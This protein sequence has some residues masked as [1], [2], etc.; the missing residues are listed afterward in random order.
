MDKSL[1]SRQLY[2]IGKDAMNALQTS[3]ILISGMTGLGVEVAKCVILSG[4][5]SV[6]L[7]DVGKLKQKELSSNYYAQESDIGRNRV[8][9]VKNMLAK[10]NPYVTV[11]TNTDILNEEHFKTNNIVVICDQLMLNQ[12][13]NN[14]IARK[15]GTKY[16]LANTMGLMGS[17][18]C[19]FGDIFNINDIDGETPKSGIIIELKDGNFCTNEP[20][21][22]YVND[23]VEINFNG[24]IRTDKVIKI[25]NSKVFKTDNETRMSEYFTNTHFT[26]IKES[27][28]INFLDLEN[29]IKSPEFVTIIDSDFERSQILHDFHNAIS[30]FVSTY[31]R[32][33]YSYDDTDAL[34]IL[35]LVN[36]K[37][38]LHKKVI[39]YLSYTCAGKLCPIDSIF[40]SIVAQEITKACSNKYMPIKQWLYMDFTSVLSESLVN[41]QLTKIKPIKIDEIY[42]RYESQISIFGT[43]FQQKLTESKIFIVGAGAIG[44]ELL[45]NL[46]MIGIGNIVITDM[47]TI[48]K[49]N[50]NRQ[51]LF[52]YEDIGKSKSECAKN[53]THKMNNLINIDAHK[54]KIASDTTHI[55][56]KDFFSGLT[57]VMNALDNVHARLFVDSL[58]IEH[59]V[60]LIDSGT[61]GTKGNTQTVI[62]F[63]TESYGSSTD[64]A[65][66]DIPMCTIKYFPYM[67]EHCIQWARNLFE[68]IFVNAPKNYIRYKNNPDEIKKLTPSELKEIV[69]DINFVYENS[70]CHYKECI[71]FGYKL[72]YEHFRD[73]TYYLQNK[74]PKDSVTDEGAPFWSGIKKYPNIIDFD[75]SDIHVE[76]IEA[77]AN[78]WADVFGK[79]HVTKKQILQYLKKATI[80]SIKLPKGEIVI[81]KDIDK[82]V[83]LDIDTDLLSTIPPISDMIDYN[84]TP[85]VF[86]KD[87]DTNFHI[88]FITNASNLRATIYGIDIA[89]KFKTK[90]IAGKIIPAIVT[91]TSLVSGIATM[92]L[93]K[94]INGFNKIENY[95]NVFLN[96]ALP[97]I[98]FSEPNKVHTHTIC[99][100]TYSL[101]DTLT[102]VDMPLITL[103]EEL[104]KKINN[105]DIDI[106]TVT[107]GQYQLFSF[108]SSAKT[109]AERLNMNLTD[110]YKHVCKENPPKSF[111]VMVSFDTEDD[112]DPLL[113][114]IISL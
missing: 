94:I 86:E 28:T 71:E 23:Y 49:S 16:I 4:V 5:K 29:S 111:T 50:L 19:D 69:D 1:Y 95:S 76:F 17:I 93:L 60:P 109:Q 31:G 74:Y 11:T 106:L 35:S 97:F 12:I 34:I 114:N 107:I 65:E 82:S 57:C 105:Y 91:T 102:F 8:D 52:G 55:Y 47:D 64:P 22:L 20:H 103:I 73:L 98:G 108:A 66:Q 61:L 33:P 7:H 59:S 37:L 80:P 90:G 9:V 89:D 77:T 113:C 67:I 92:E 40:G 24:S 51:F 85:L 84:I 78:L 39:K 26:Q 44:C 3:S 56:N 75:N 45:K 110:I 54:N 101:W 112:S 72:W 43:E 41:E 14:K 96:L 48:E 63:V 21:Q 62:P 27:I 99:D 81:N 32:L 10:L 18:F 79:Q 68:G 36:P 25:I 53:A 42:S 38:E 83:S 6:V 15:Y 30:Y 104:H 46:A 58:C 87:D 88:D 2:T 13:K 100:Y 70:V